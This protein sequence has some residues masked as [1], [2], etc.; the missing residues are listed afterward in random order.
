MICSRKIILDENLNG[1]AFDDEH[2][3]CESCAK[4]QSEEDIMKWT[5]TIMQNPTRGMPIAL[6]IIHEE[7]KDKTIMTSNVPP[8]SPSRSVVSDSLKDSDE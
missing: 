3:L 6:W 2:F 4:N 8:M 5:S 1:L 7:N